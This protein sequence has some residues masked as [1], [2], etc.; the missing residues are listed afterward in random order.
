MG[1]FFH[2]KHS[3]LLQFHPPQHSIVKKDIAHNLFDFPL[4]KCGV[5]WKS[6]FT[7]YKSCHCIY[8]YLGVSGNKY[9][10]AF[11]E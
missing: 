5:L 8:I 10:E 11:P 7:V 9:I 2:S 1:Y 4:H 3:Y 6:E